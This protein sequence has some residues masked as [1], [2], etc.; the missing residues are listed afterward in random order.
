MLPKIT[1]DSGASLTVGTSAVDS[2]DSVINNLALPSGS[3][4]GGRAAVTAGTIGNL[5]GVTLTG[6]GSLT[7]GTGGTGT[8]ASS[9]TLSLEGGYLVSNK[10]TLTSTD[11]Q[12]VFYDGKVTNGG[13]WTL[14]NPSVEAFYNQSGAATNT[15]TNSAAG[16]SQLPLSLATTPRH[17]TTCRSSTTAPWRSPRDH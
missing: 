16:T 9:T 3:A 10:G 6:I 4:F 7:L 1:V 14:K 11:G 13:T 8:L 17:S 15:Y 5:S 2:Y 12:V